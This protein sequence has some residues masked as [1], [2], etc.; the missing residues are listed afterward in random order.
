MLLIGLPLLIGTGCR[1]Q[2]EVIFKQAPAIAHRQ[3]LNS[4]GKPASYLIQSW[5]EL[6]MKLIIETPGHTPPIAARSFGYAGVTVYESL[7]G[8]MPL[9]H[10]LA[11]QLNGLTSLP[12]RQ[13]GNSYSAIL[14]ANT[15]LA[16]II[17]NLFQNASRDN[18]IRI[19]SLE[20]ANNHLHTGQFSEEILER[21]RNFGYAVADAV[22]NWSLTGGGHQAFLNNFPSGYLAPTGIDKWIP[23]FP[24]YQNAMLPYWGNNRPMVPANNAGPIDPPPPPAFSTSAASAFYKAAYEVYTTGLHH[25]AEEKTI[26]LYWADGSGTFTPPGHNI[27]IALQMI[28]N[29]HLNLY[30][31]ATMMAKVG[32]AE[33]DAGIVCWRAKFNYNLIRPITFIRSYIDPS[34]T[35]LIVTP[36]FPSYTSGHSSFSGAAAAILTNEIGDHVFFIDS[37]KI[38]YG[39]LPRS[40]N[41]FRDAAQE[42]A[43]SRLYGGIHYAFD[44]ENGFKC[45]ELIALNVEH[46][47]WQN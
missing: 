21:S 47:H 7:V 22:F 6:M 34:W 2:E 4:E 28:R 16:R 9:Y 8:E 15:A 3:P 26:A 41:S 23:T 19:D 33:N 46:L 45:G 38:A 29:H 30:D 40:F 12:L 14:T 35:P 11:G 1:K 36:P 25:S 39:F 44:N 20:T 27:A 43:V 18:L 32:I 10:S 17:K 42:A 24:T 37:S 5:F 13:Y 31:A